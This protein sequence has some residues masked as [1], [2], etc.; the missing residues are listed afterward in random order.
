MVIAVRPL[1]KSSMFTMDLAYWRLDKT[2]MQQMVGL[3]LPMF[4]NSAVISI[5][6]GFVSRN[7]N[8]IGPFFTAGISSGTKIFTMLESVIMA[9]Q[10][11]LSV[12]IGQNLG[13]NKLDRVRQGQHQIVV[14]SLAISVVLNVIVQSLAPQFAT[15]FLSHSDPEL[16]ARTLHVA[17]TYTR[18]ITLGLFVMAPMYLYRIAI[19]TLGHPKYP[20]YA[21]FLQLGARVFAVTVLPTYIGEYAYYAATI[22]AWLVTLPI[23]VIPYYRYS[24]E[25]R[26]H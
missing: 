15:I 5:G 16:Y 3:W 10:T 12:F 13:A 24:R 20:M 2:F 6:G 26:S 1:L 14:L 17:V 18:V 22:L 4:V 7:V 21:G 25:R 23:V 9:I 19:Q 11:G 8:A